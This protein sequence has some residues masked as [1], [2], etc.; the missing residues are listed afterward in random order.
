MDPVCVA[1][2]AIVDVIA[3]CDEAFL[4][5]NGISKGAMNLIDTRRAELLYSRMGPAIEASGGSAGN[6]AAAPPSSASF[7]TMRSAKSARMTS[8][9]RA[10]PSTPGRSR[11]SRRRRAR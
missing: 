2:S 9:H 5:T 4:K 6:L 8:T 11:A 3:Q 7:R 10:S 1:V